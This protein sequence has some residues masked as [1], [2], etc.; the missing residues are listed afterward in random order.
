MCLQPA[1]NCS[2]LLSKNPGCKVLLQTLVVVC[3]SANSLHFVSCAFVDLCVT[4][5]AIST[6]ASG[7]AFEAQFRLAQ[8]SELF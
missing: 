8:A 5:A 7:F 1:I 6:T 4:I 3:D 2:L